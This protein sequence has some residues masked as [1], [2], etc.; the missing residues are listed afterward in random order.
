MI[1]NL[2]RHLSPTVLDTEP[3]DALDCDTQAVEDFLEATDLLVHMVGK[4]RLQH[5]LNQCLDALR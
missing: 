1:E 2:E 5:L 3:D 4:R